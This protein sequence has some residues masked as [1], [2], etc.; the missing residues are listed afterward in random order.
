MSDQPQMHYVGYCRICG[1]GLLG[2]RECGR[3]GEVVVLCDECDSVW[4]DGDF[5]VKPT[6]AGENDLPCPFCEASLLLPPSRWATKSKIDKLAWL[7]TAVQTGDVEVKRSATLGDEADDQKNS[8][9][10]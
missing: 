8:D 1:T 2:L 7:Q 6:I 4:T 10:R 9:T 3:C 5:S